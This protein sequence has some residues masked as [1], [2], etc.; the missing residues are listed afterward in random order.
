MTGKLISFVIPHKGRENLLKQTIDSIAAQEFDLSK[1]EVIVVTQNKELS[2]DLIDL[3]KKI[4][5]SVYNRPINESISSLRNYGVKESR[6]EFLAFLDADIYISSNWINCM[7]DKLNATESGRVLI[8]AIQTNS[9]AADSVEKIRTALHNK[10]K[11]TNQESLHGSNLFLRAEAFQL[12]GGFPRDLITCEDVYF[13]SKLTAFGSLY[14]TSAATFIH[15]GEDKDFKSMFKKE[16]WRGQSNLLSIEGRSIPIKEIPSFIIPIAI[17]VFFVASITSIAFGYN[18]L[19]ILFIAL[20]LVPIALYSMRLYLLV[21]DKIPFLDI[22][23]FY[24]IYFPA[25]AIGTL[26]GV[27]KTL[28]LWGKK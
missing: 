4:E 10:T 12:V 6:G 16:I 22:I 13:T 2:K 11:D 7:L 23:K 17:L 21:G 14:L 3:Q 19:A 26:R 28:S 24:A 1:V 27:L 20:Y 25:R 5:L 15:L 18:S 9:Q 8:S